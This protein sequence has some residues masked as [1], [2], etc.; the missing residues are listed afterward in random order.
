M[1]VR[2]NISV[3]KPAFRK[4]AIDIV[5]RGFL[6]VFVFKFYIWLSRLSSKKVEND[7]I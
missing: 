7:S 2:E 4:Q 5:L 6:F 3:N 1:L